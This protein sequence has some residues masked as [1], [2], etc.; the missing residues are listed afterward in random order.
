[1]KLVPQ[2]RFLLFLALL[3][4]GGALLTEK[5]WEGGAHERTSSLVGPLFPELQRQRQ[6]IDQIQL[7]S[8]GEEVTLLRTST[9]FVVKEK[10]GHPA[11]STRVVQLIDSLSLLDNRDVVS[12]NPE[13]RTTFGV[14]KGS[15]TQILVQNSRGEILADLIGGKLRAAD[16][17][18]AAQV[19]LDFYVR[20]SGRNEVFLVNA[21]QPP[22]TEASDWLAGDLFSLN[23]EDIALASRLEFTSGETWTLVHDG[24]EAWHMENPEPRDIDLYE[25]DSWAFSF[26]N[27]RASDVWAHLEQGET[28]SPEFGFSTNVFRVEMGQGKP[29]ELRLG[30][31]APNSDRY[32]WV[33]GS[34]WIYSVPNH[35]VDQLCM[36]FSVVSED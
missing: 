1:M 33:V 30:G 2:N 22:S 14:E 32:A 3:L 15:G 23:A 9:G 29:L 7:R 28:P 31:L 4:W 11:S 18:T 21:Y 34:E 25:G 36:P 10:W 27:L 8:Q 20:P 6:E 5:P 35:E 26:S 24:P 17:F 12:T 13:K 19:R 16:P